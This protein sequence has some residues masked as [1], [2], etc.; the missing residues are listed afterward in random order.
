M[1]LIGKAKAVIRF[2]GKHKGEIEHIGKIGKFA[3]Q[4]YRRRKM[5]MM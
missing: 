4:Q 2:I 1:S 3:Y 5:M